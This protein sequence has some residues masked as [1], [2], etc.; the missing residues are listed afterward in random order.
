MIFL[1]Q[2]AVFWR[3]RSQRCCYASECLEVLRLQYLGK[4]KPLPEFARKLFNFA[5][6]RVW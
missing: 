4:G 6:Q 1:W 3:T 5:L 2:R